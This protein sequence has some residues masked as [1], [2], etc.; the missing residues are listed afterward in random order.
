MTIQIAIWDLMRG[1]SREGQFTSRKRALMHLSPDRRVRR[2][3]VSIP[4]EAIK[5]FKQEAWD[6]G[7]ID[8]ARLCHRALTEKSRDALREAARMVWGAHP[9]RYEDR[10]L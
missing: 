9:E 1:S 8:G 3:I 7:D 2:R 5:A 10:A 6:A 4:F